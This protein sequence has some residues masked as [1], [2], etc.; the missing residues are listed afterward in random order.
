MIVSTKF[1]TPE[2]LA[3]ERL[4]QIK[5]HYYKINFVLNNTISVQKSLLANYV[6]FHH[7]KKFK[8]NWVN[9]PSNTL[10]HFFLFRIDEFLLYNW[11]PDYESTKLQETLIT[12]L[13][14]GIFMYVVVVLFLGKVF[15]LRYGSFNNFWQPCN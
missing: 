15:M 3:N 10:R 12:L 13:T 14:C 9:K 5:S 1:E 6:N 11:L 7:L 8:R 4:R 2:T